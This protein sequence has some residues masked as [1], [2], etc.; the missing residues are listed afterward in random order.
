MVPSP[1]E[2]AHHA[3]PLSAAPPAET[4]PAELEA[5][6]L[7]AARLV[8]RTAAH[9]VNNALAPVVGFAE[10][11]AL[12]PEI[13]AH[14]VLKAYAEHLLAAGQRAAAAVSRLQHLTRLEVEPAAP[15]G[16]TVLDLDRSTA[17]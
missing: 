2:P 9:H 3:I 11:L 10:L 4:L 5:A 12:A 13:Q 14:P 17:P 6:R 15:H 16:F 7:E 8:A 1:A